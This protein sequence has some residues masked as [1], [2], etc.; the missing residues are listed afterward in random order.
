MP[1][2]GPLGTVPRARSLAPGLGLSLITRPSSRASG[3]LEGPSKGAAQQQ[4]AHLGLAD[5]P[6]LLTHFISAVSNP[7]PAIQTPTLRTSFYCRQVKEADIS[8][9]ECHS[10][11]SLSFNSS[12]LALAAASFR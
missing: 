4:A 6:Q 7:C 11:S 10:E 1:G 5:V 12:M 9:A 3:A 8:S 2:G